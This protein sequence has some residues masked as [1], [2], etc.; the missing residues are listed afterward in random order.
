MTRQTGMSD[1]Y[2]VD[3]VRI[4]TA[5]AEESSAVRNVID[6]G[7]LEI[8][9]ETLS[10]AVETG[11]VLVA[12]REDD[13]EEETILGV[14]VLSD[15]EI[16]AIAVRKRRQAQG[17]GTA[18]VEVAARRQDSL[19]AEFHARVRPFWESLGFTVEPAEEAERFLGRRSI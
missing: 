15:A 6:G 19:H 3:G 7:L 1:D 5:R 18:L 2:R 4:R 10:D 11:N 9:T 12:V 16:R 13:V 17:I 8:D 14:L